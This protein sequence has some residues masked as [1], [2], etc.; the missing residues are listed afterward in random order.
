MSEEKGKPDSD[1]DSVQLKLKFCCGNISLADDPEPCPGRHPDGP[2]INIKPQPG[3]EILEPFKTVHYG[4]IDELKKS[5]EESLG[6][7]GK[8]KDLTK[9]NAASPFR[10]WD[11]LSEKRTSGSSNNALRK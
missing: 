7:S 5:F 2:Q 8:K 9:A 4:D 1:S 10:L 11:P 3:V 6:K